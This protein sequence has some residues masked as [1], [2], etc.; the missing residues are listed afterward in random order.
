MKAIK[1]SNG[2]QEKADGG[3]PTLILPP[4]DPTTGEKK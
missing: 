1:E 3:S 2:I 4:I